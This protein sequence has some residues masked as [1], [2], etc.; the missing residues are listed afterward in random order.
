MAGGEVADVLR[1]SRSD[2]GDLPDVYL[3]SAGGLARTRQGRKISIGVVFLQVFFRFECS[4]KCD[5]GSTLNDM[6]TL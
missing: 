2:G 5:A 4:N 3:T 1:A 6:E